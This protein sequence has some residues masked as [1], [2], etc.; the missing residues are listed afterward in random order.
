MQT[1]EIDFCNCPMIDV[2]I[3]IFFFHPDWTTNHGDWRLESGE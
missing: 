2:V 3:V 1:Q